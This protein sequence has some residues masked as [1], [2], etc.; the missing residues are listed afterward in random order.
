M[1]RYVKPNLLYSE[2]LKK[3]QL[4]EVSEQKSNGILQCSGKYLN[5]GKIAK[6]KNAKL[7]DFSI[8]S[9]GKVVKRESLTDQCV[10]HMCRGLNINVGKKPKHENKVD[11]FVDTN[12]Y[13]VLADV[14]FSV[15][16]TCQ[17]VNVNNVVRQSDGEK[18]HEASVL[19]KNGRNHTKGKKS[20]STVSK[21]MY[22]SAG[23]PKGSSC[24]SKIGVSRDIAISEQAECRTESSAVQTYNS[25]VA[26][27]HSVDSDKYELEIQSKLRKSKIQVA[28]RALENEKCMQQNKP[29]FGFI[30]IYG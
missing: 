4:A 22:P 28:K 12:P 16:N 21:I 27:A 7:Y 17:P 3:P 20:Q 10:S 15:V 30:P 14:D 26:T 9:P 25:D 23:G 13:S 5:C 19:M 18:C 29:L 2:V 24:P 6:G 1:C 11:Q 8:E